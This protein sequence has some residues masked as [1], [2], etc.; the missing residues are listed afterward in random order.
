MRAHEAGA[1]HA[2][3]YGGPPHWLPWPTDVMELLPQLW[4]KTVGRDDAGRLTVGGLDVV[5]IAREFGTAAY[6]VDEEDFRSRARA[7]RDDF[8]APFADLGGVDVFY[9]GKAFLCTEVA[10]W[11]AEEGLSLD[12]CT[13]GELAVAL[14][15]GFPPGR[16][17][18]HGN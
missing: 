2:E 7:F 15:A 3:G 4:P 11:V 14:R 1:L 6:V 8:G 9:A 13:D 5:T 12:V 17:L 16:L 18:F 10:R